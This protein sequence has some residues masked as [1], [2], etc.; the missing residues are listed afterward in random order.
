MKKF[1][2][3]FAKKQFGIGLLELMLSLSIIAVLLVMATRYYMS[4]A[5]NSRVNQT[6]DAVMG[7][8]AAAECWASS[9]QN[10][11]PATQ[12]NYGG[13]DLTKVVA[14]KCFPASLVPTGAPKL[15]ITPYGQMTITSTASRVCVTITPVPNN[16]LKQLVN[17]ICPAY[18]SSIGTATTVAYDAITQTCA[19]AVATLGC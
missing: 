16:E 6:A 17:K 13:I 7:L 5:T 10:T 11:A 1:R 2:F 18:T 14:D 15:I 12:G 19:A 9:A 8:A 3:L 4:A